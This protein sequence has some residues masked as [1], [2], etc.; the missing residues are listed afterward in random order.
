MDDVVR[1]FNLVFNSMDYLKF[2]ATN[3]SMCRALVQALLIGGSMLPVA[4]VHSAHGRSDLEVIAG[5]R[6]W[7][8]EIKFACN[9]QDS[10]KLLQE[11]IA[12][13]P[14]GLYGEAFAGK[15]KKTLMRVVLVFSSEKRQF[16]LWAAV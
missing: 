4:E 11:G 2:P 16:V 10:S 6:R 13:M 5:D 12:Q 1:Y 7:V 3:E 8:F 15:T 14:E 9:E